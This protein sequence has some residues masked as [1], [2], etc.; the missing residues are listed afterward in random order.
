[1]NKTEI[2]K[3]L[4]ELGACVEKEHPREPY[5][6]KRRI[7]IEN[8]IID[9]SQPVVSE[10]KHDF[11]GRNFTIEISNNNGVRICELIGENKYRKILLTSKFF[12]EIVKKLNLEV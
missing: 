2:R 3:L 7:E 1:M 12:G 5:Y 11:C 10:V 9:L 6:A 4:K 8:I